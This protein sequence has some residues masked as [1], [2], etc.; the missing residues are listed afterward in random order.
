M[1]KWLK[2]IGIALAIAIGLVVVLAWWLL[3]TESGARFAVERAKSSLAGK[4]ALAGM[5]GALTSPLEL[6]DVAYK[7]PASGLD[8]KVKTLRLDYEFWGLLR[9]TVHVRG[10]DI[11]GVEIA[12]TTVPPA[13]LPPTAAQP[14]IAQ[15]LTPPVDILLDRLHVGATKITQDGKP[16]FASDTL[17]AAAT[18]TSSALTLKQLA[19]RAPDGKLDLAGAITQYKDVVGRGK[20][21]LDWAIPNQSGPAAPDSKAPPMRAVAS[22]DLDNDG[23]QAHFTLAASQPLVANAKGSLTPN[24]KN[25]PW[26]IDLDVPA[27]NPKKLTQSDTLNSLA[28]KLSGN[29]DRNA[30]TL[31]GNVDLNEHRVLLD[32][33]KFVS[34]GK[35]LT[36]DPLRL[37]SPEAQGALTAQAKIHLDAKPVGG[38]IKLDWADVVLPADLAGQEL[39]THGSISA[40][41]NA[42][43]FNA[44]GELAIGPHDPKQ[45]VRVANLAFKLDAT[46]EKISLA[47]LEL[48][49]PKG[50]L[51]AT[52]EIVL[53]PQVGWNIE[54]KANQF[55]PGAF[56]KDWSGAVNFQL[57]TSGNVEKD[58]P[59]GK[60]RLDQ[61]GGTLRLRPLA[62]SGELAFA[63]PLSVDGKLNVSSGQSTVA[64]VGKGG[65]GKD[66]ATDLKIDLNVASLGDWVPKA[67]GS[68]RGAIAVSGAYP[69]L[70]AS[71][72]LGGSA[73]VSGDAH[74]QAFT[75]D[76][77]AKDLSAPSGRLAL[78]AKTLSAAGY[79]FDTV[80]LD[81][82]GTQAAHQ[83]KLDVHG[84][85]LSLALA[86]DGALTQNQ[87]ASDWRG[88]LKTL[89]LD[90][91][92]LPEWK[93]AQPTPL[94]YV[95]GVFN[96]SELCLRAGAPG[97]CAQATQ[98]AKSGTNAKFR[99]EHLP[100]AMLAR[101]GSPDATMKLDGE[102]NGNGTIVIVPSGALSGNVSITSDQGTIVYP[103]SA[104]KALL[105]YK[106]FR[107]D[108][109]LAPAQN[110]VTIA[111]D[112][113]DGG[114]IDGHI[115]TG[116]ADASGA[117]PLSGSLALNINNLSFVDFLTTQVSGT[118]GKVEAKFALSGSTKK[119]GVD[120]Q[121]ALVGFA[122]EV[123]AAGL[124]LRDG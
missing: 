22:V 91:Q 29:G 53:K 121:L 123:P 122:T 51:N 60:L 41:G 2:R 18:W 32:P 68:V 124:K 108:A 38:E 34:D 36:F 20:L 64:L 57:S 102:L 30:G 42:D 80:R 92:G 107:V 7:D 119:P 12:L 63:P 58:G 70:D 90:Q 11:D 99:L 94:S 1:K 55:D 110:T 33:L 46:P 79:T 77:D 72:K 75:L 83:L 73:I 74:L 112:L 65:A 61:L 49:Q 85:P 116:A 76:F 82:N 48:K 117:M 27:F 16:V 109:A 69:K 86:L 5:K 97:I 31:S 81:A 104:S 47:Q 100:L 37:R 120:G 106:G 105:S 50:G 40:G 3:G 44:Q 23:K 21:D 93:L 14:S 89:T 15:L 59:A 6:H 78:D 118:K 115:V 84:K 101:L 98:D 103:D 96:L 10:L 87:N 17:D 19:L 67:G 25:L 54:A 8:V 66:A 113:N 28:L 71:G 111:G 88:T 13:P 43:K 95:G 35:T 62:G 56:A 45:S 39:A 52:G 24:D 9:K 4:L 26:A 114:R